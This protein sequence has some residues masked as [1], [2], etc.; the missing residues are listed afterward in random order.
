MEAAAG[1]RDKKIP[2]VWG[3]EK[4]EG[5]GGPVQRGYTGDTRTTEKFGMKRL[6][7]AVIGAKVD[8]GIW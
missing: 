3:K 4:R 6:K 5:G 1:K 8:G 2:A 7:K